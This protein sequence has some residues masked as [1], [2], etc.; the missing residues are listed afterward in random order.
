MHTRRT[1]H[2][3]RSA[4]CRQ[5]EERTVSVL[6]NDPAPCVP[7]WTEPT[8]PLPHIGRAGALTPGA[9]VSIMPIPRTAHQDERPAWDRKI[10]S[11]SWPGAIA[12]TE[13]AGQSDASRTARRSL[14]PLT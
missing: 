7:R 11:E 13:L 8:M 3:S 2:Q 4:G 10:C 12:I 5:R 6:V 1:L 9:A 14:W